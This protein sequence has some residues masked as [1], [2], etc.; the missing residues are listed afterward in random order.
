MKQIV[1]SFLKKDFLVILTCSFSPQV[2]IDGSEV[3]LESNFFNY[4][5]LS[6]KSLMKAEQRNTVVFKTLLSLPFYNISSKLGN[7]RKQMIKSTWKRRDCIRLQIQAINLKWF[8]FDQILILSGLY[9]VQFIQAHSH[10][11]TSET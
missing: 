5:Y 7:P 3:T 2:N 10:T 11:S 6:A 4:R 9:F 8:S 1:F